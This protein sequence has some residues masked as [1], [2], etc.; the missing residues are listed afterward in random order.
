MDPNAEHFPLFNQDVV[1]SFL[2]GGLSLHWRSILSNMK[3]G[4]A[5]SWGGAL[6]RPGLSPGGTLSSGPPRMPSWPSWLNERM[7]S[8]L[9]AL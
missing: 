7:R 1:G 2:V 4:L 3:Q 5:R 9:H 6:F 8:G